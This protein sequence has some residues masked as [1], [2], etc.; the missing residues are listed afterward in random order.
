M[1]NCTDDTSRNNECESALQQDTDQ[2]KCSPRKKRRAQQDYPAFV[3]NFV[4]RKVL[5]FKTTVICNDVR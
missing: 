1:N 5:M 4:L 3:Q 2:D